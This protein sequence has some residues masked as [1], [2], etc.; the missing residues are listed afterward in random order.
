MAASKTTSRS[1]GKPVPGRK[2]VDWEA[3]ERDYRTGRYS[4]RELGA[5][6]AANHATIGRRSEKEGWTK[7][8]TAAIRQATNA[9][10][11]ET[12]TRQHCDGARQSATETVLVAAELNRQVILGHRARVGKATDV[13]MRMLAELD[14]TTLKAG[15]L[16]ALFERITEDTDG[17]ALAAAQQQ[18]REFMRLHARVG[19]AQKLM[20]ALG[21][22]QTLERQAFGLDDA[23]KPPPADRK[24]L[25]LSD[26]EL[27]EQILADRAARAQA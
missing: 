2:R 12:E 9:K 27:V 23:D 13:A 20:A 25:D 8:L 1:P 10:L 26:D 5:K 19:S 22:A 24:P 6:H 18:F 4:L 15:E 14:A 17:P 7:D 21:T 11:I 16:E 3:V